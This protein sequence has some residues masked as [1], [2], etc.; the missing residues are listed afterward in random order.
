MSPESSFGANRD[1]AVRFDAAAAD[2]RFV[3]NV[4]RVLLEDFASERNAPVATK[5]TNAAWL[6]TL[7]NGEP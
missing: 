3:S 4:E 2:G 5:E 7:E 6:A 1:S